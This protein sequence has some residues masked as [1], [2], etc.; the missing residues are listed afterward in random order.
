MKVE[1]TQMK[2]AKSEQTGGMIGF[3]SRNARTHKLNGVCEDSKYGKK[4]CVLSAD[5]E[6]KIIPN[7][8]YAVEV[9]AMHKGG[10]YVVVSAVPMLF[11]TVVET[12]AIPKTN[13]QVTVSFGNK[14]VHFDPMNGRT[15]YSTTRVGVII[16]LR[17]R[18][19]IDN[20]EDV[21]KEFIKQADKLVERIKR[22]GYTLSPE[23]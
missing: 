10:G 12:I 11:Q 1:S 2:F 8:L 17:E 7:R 4:I 19:D 23:C 20:I 18:D 5:L 16:V 3:V 14:I 6:G 21:V 13:Y 22:D 15:I 9:K